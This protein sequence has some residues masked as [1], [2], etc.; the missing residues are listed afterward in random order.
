MSEKDNWFRPPTIPYG[1]QAGTCNDQ[2]G[3]R[4]A[5]RPFDHGDGDRK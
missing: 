4:E 3:G 1:D 2:H 5:D